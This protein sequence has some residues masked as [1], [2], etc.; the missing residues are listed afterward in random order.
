MYGSPE[1]LEVCMH[2]FSAVILFLLSGMF[3]IGQTP[4]N[5]A[6][7]ITVLPANTVNQPLVYALTTPANFG[8]PVNFSAS[9]QASSQMML[10]GDASNS[11][12]IQGLHITLNRMNTPAIDSIEVTVYGLSANARVLPVETQPSDV[13]TKTFELNRTA[14][15]AT[16]KDADVWMHKVGALRWVDLDSINY[17]DGTT[18]H[19]TNNLKCRAV[20]SNFVLVGSN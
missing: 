14:G 7:T 12:P 18:W 2:R 8:C 15:T 20:P 9:R 4:A 5:S 10:A 13:V 19:A 16:L 3:A 6:S 17:A 1:V 11:G